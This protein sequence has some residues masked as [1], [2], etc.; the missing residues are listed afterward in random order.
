MLH[1]IHGRI[2]VTEDK[3]RLVHEINIL[4]T[5]LAEK[6]DSNLQAIKDTYEEQLDY[7]TRR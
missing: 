2:D 1:P 3:D 4:S 6:F 7:I 5:M